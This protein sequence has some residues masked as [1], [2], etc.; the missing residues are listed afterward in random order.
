MVDLQIIFLPGCG[1]HVL[2]G[3]ETTALICL[4]SVM[5]ENAVYYDRIE[6]TTIF[7]AIATKPRYEDG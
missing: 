2:S 3:K 1:T 6:L 5:M 7:I 4:P